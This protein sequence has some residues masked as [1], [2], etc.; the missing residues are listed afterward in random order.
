MLSVTQGES[1]ARGEE[2]PSSGACVRV[3]G[4]KVNAVVI[5]PGSTQSTRTNT[6]LMP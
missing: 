2:K 3:F 6:A 1:N 4:R 5:K